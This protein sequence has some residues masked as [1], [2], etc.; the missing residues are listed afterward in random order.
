MNRGLRQRVRRGGRQTAV[1][2]QDW[3]PTSGGDGKIGDYALLDGL[4]NLSGIVDPIT[5]GHV[6]LIERGARLFDTLVVAVLD[7]ETKQALFTVEERVAM[8]REAT[9]SMANVQVDC[10]DGLLVEYAARRGAGV[11]LRGIRAISD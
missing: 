11:I 10:F 7:N 1:R 2:C 6:D 8:L 5:N 9:G 4:R 3:L